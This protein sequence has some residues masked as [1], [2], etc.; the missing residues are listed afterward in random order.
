[1]I[2]EVTLRPVLDPD[3]ATPGHLFVGRGRRGT[4]CG[5]NVMESKIFLKYSMHSRDTKTERKKK[6]T[7]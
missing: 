5:E 6:L 1:M 2:P 3:L 7:I 4:F